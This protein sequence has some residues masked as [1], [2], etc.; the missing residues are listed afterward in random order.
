MVLEIIQKKLEQYHVKN[1]LEEAHAIKEISQEIALMALSRTDFFQKAAFC[2]GTALRILYGLPRF[3]EDLDFILE[4]T[5]PRFVWK[6][7]LEKIGEEM[8]VY[9]YRIEI[10]DRGNIDRNVR[11]A[12]LKDDSIGKILGLSYKPQ[13]G[14]LKKIKIKLEIDVNPPLGASFELKYL[15][16]PVLF[17]VRALDKSSLFAG[18]LH[19]LLCRQYIKGRDWYD[20]LWYMSQDVDVN[21]LFLKNAI[22]QAGPWAKKNEK[23]NSTWLKKQLTKKIQEIDWNKTL[24][25]VSPFIKQA[26]LA[27]LKLWSADLFISKV[28]KLR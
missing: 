15:D 28:V 17:S 13:Q 27:S 6:N 10:V 5:N 8:K 24:D 9:G 7:Y 23:V 18:K 14:P 11:L 19:A 20:F 25:D 16:F 3:S 12:F 26:E 21:Y 22:D 2:G 1:T 4:N